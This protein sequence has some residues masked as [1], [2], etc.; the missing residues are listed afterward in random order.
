MLGRI[1]HQQVNVVVFA[2]HLNQL[3]FEVS[4]DVGEDG[5]KSDDGVT[6]KYPISILGDED[7]VYVN[8]KHTVS[9]VSDFT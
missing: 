2:V 1:V 3:G 5:P 9:T 4:T 6:V 7:Q 8:L